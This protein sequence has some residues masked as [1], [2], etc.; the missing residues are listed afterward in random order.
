[1]TQHADACLSGADLAAA[2]QKSFVDGP[3]GIIFDC[4][5]VMVDSNQANIHYYNLLRE[6]LGL[7]PLPKDMEG[8]LSMCTTPEA[9]AAIVPSSLYP[10]L[11]DVAKKISYQEE[12]QPLFQ[13]MPGLRDMLDACK[14]QGLKLAIDT[15]R[16]DS[17]L[18]LLDQFQM[19][20]IFD[21]VVT[22]LQVS[23]KP[24]P[25]GALL[26]L[27]QWRLPP[28]RVLFVGDSSTDR[29]AAAAA[30]IPF[31]AFGDHEPS[32]MGCCSSFAEFLTALQIVWD[33]N[34]K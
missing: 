14:A 18:P 8:Y 6:G 16:S 10:A 20:D 3:E 31:L 11:R 1:M 34:K 24:D 25:E 23:P 9:F 2:L 17:M 22:A 21:P 12:I 26:I 30:G 33:Y 32:D 7:P 28:E 15:N 13:P 4:D 5:G 19:E 29:R 27:D